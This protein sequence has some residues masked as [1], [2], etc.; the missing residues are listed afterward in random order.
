MQLNADIRNNLA[1]IFISYSSLTIKCTQFPGGSNT[2]ILIQD[3]HKTNTISL[4]NASRIGDYIT[5]TVAPGRKEFLSTF[6]VSS[7]K[8]MHQDQEITHVIS[9]HIKKS[10]VSLVHSSKATYCYAVFSPSTTPRL[11]HS[12]SVASSIYNDGWKKISVYTVNPQKYCRNQMWQFRP[13]Y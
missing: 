12:R 5:V 4:V 10:K 8:Q 1:K 7:S 3:K 11:T 2:N 6:F 9:K 13:A